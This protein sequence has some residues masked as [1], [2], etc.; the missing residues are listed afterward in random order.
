MINN[1]FYFFVP[2]GYNWVTADKPSGT[3]ARCDALIEYW[4]KYS[5]SEKFCQFIL[6]ADRP[7]GSTHTPMAVEMAEYIST[8]TNHVLC[9]IPHP[10]GWGTISEIERSVKLIREQTRTAGPFVRVHISTNPGHMLRVWLYWK[11]LAPKEW[12][13]IFVPAQHSFSKKEWFQETAKVLRDLYR[14]ATGKIKRTET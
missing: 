12:E 14:I 7:E 1:C 4:K 3:E 5:I 6:T 9:P 11:V 10:Q 13:V 8:R 2:L